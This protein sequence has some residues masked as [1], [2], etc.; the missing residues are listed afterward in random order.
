ML[1]LKMAKASPWDDIFR[2][3][4]TMNIKHEDRRLLRLVCQG[5]TRLEVANRTGLQLGDV[6]RRLRAILRAMQRDIERFAG[7]DQGSVSTGSPSRN[8]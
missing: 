6:D 2:T 4:G 5:C 1:T 7:V 8:G 3:G